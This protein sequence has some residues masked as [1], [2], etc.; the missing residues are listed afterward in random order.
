MQV[1]MEVLQPEREAMPSGNICQALGHAAGPGLPFPP[2]L[3][4]WRIMPVRHSFL[5]VYFTRSVLIP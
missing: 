4:Y 3:N 1:N 2:A 5:C